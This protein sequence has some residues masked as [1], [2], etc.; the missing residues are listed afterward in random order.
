NVQLTK[1]NDKAMLSRTSHWHYTELMKKEDT[2]KEI[3]LQ[4]NHTK[5]KKLDWITVASPTFDRII[6]FLKEKNRYIHLYESIET[7]EKPLMQPWL[8][9]NFSL[10]YE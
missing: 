6:Y 2:P 8:L 10:L 4:T 1:A 3:T 5:E 9:V 7:S